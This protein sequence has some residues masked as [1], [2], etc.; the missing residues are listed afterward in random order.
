MKYAES[1][2]FIDL[3]ECLARVEGV[4]PTNL[5]Y[6]VSEYIDP[7]AIERLEQM[8]DGV[9]ELTFTCS[10]HTVT[11]THRNEIEIDGQEFGKAEEMR[12]I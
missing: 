1:S 7:E 8:E 6:N 11:V 5:E 12:E 2:L 3:V 9:W 10:D 4:E